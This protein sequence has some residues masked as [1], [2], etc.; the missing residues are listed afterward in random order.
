[1]ERLCRIYWRPVYAFIRWKH[2]CDPEDAK[3]LTQAF[4]AELLEKQG[5]KAANPKRG[6]FRNF[7]LEAAT[8]FLCNEWDKNRTIKRGGRFSFISLDATAA[9][10]ERLEEPSEE[11]SAEREFDRKW[12]LTL[13]EQARA[14]LRKQ[15]VEDGKGDIF[16]AMDLSLGEMEAKHPYRD[17]AVALGK[18]EG[19]LKVAFHRLKRR[20]GELLR[21]E[22]AQT[23]RRPEDMEDELRHLIAALSN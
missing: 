4:F 16:D 9:E 10:G 12:A 22:V 19:T 14:R 11:R 20:F 17:W 2:R 6:Q 7:L 8:H 15:Y 18:S 23:V 5:L 1:L 3:D 13:V 21:E